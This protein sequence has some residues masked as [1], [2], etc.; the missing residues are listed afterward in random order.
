MPSLGIFTGNTGCNSMSGSFNFNGSD[1]KV[2]KR[3][4]TSKMACN[5]YDESMFIGALLKADNYSLNN[6]L[7]ELKQGTTTLMSF[8]RKV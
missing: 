7:L 1:I 8:K 5:D 4:R 3:I 6:G 2:D